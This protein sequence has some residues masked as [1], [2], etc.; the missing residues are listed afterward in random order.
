[1]IRSVSATAHPHAAPPPPPSGG[2]PRGGVPPP[3]PAPPP[4]PP[5]PPPPR[6][7]PPPPRRAAP[8]EGARAR[9]PGAG[10]G[11]APRTRRADLRPVGVD[12]LGARDHPSRPQHGQRTVV[13]AAADPLHDA[14]RAV[15]RRRRAGPLA[16]D[17]P[18][19]RPARD[20]DG[21]SPRLAPR[22]AR[23]R[24]DRRGRVGAGGG[25]RAQLRARRL[26]GAARRAVP[27]GG[28]APPRRP[29]HRRLPAR[30]RRGAPAP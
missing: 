24:A 8:V 2:G 9:V 4:P 10:G 15:G 22:R 1:M 6:G 14:L 13:E 5:P 27:V 12:H 25:V 16:A 26:R 28:R 18:R 30:P 11:V 17:R 29:P 21:L 20:R 19:G 3:R 7:G 23:R